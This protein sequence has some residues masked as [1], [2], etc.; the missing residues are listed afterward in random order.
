MEE[1]AGC[2]QFEVVAVLVAGL[3]D[4]GQDRLLLQTP[5]IL[6]DG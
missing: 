5:I 2:R 6:Q 3:H 4:G 1:R